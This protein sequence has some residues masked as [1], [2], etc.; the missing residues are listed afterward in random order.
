MKIITKFS[1]FTVIMLLLAFFSSP[2]ARAFTVEEYLAN[3]PT[4]TAWD[5]ATSCDGDY[6]SDGI[7][8]ICNAEGFTSIGG[9]SM[10]GVAMYNIQCDDSQTATMDFLVR[11]RLNSTGAIL[12]ESNHRTITCSS[13]PPTNSLNTP[14]TYFTFGT[15]YAVTAGPTYA[16]SYE[17][18][19]LTELNDAWARGNGGFAA[20][21]LSGTGA[22]TLIWNTPADGYVGPSFTYWTYETSGLVSSTAYSVAVTYSTVGEPY[23]YLYQDVYSVGSNDAIYASPVQHTLWYPGFASTTHWQYYGQL[24]DGNN[25]VIDSTD[26]MDMWVNGLASTTYPNYNQINTSSTING[27]NNQI[28]NANGSSTCGVAY[29]CTN[30]DSTSWFTIDWACNLYYAGAQVGNFLFCPPDFTSN[31]MNDAVANLK[32]VDPFRTVFAIVDTASTS[33]ASVT[34]TPLAITL[35]LGGHDTEFVLLNADS[36][37]KST[38]AKNAMFLFWRSFLYVGGALAGIRMITQGTES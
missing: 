13:S 35:N 10:S 24:L 4:P 28:R 11:L 15:P 2:L 23:E 22:S 17:T 31:I 5:H 3:A 26:N 29:T 38:G 21:L 8:H 33:I 7:S 37:I 9:Y 14:L 27:F 32:T 19:A 20:D 16:L 36:P 30:H 18:V 34:S 12:A 1:V 6:W 25:N